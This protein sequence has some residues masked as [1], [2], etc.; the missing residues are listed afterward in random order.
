MDQIPGAL[1][2][3]MVI[4]SIGDQV[5]PN[6][7]TSPLAGTTPLAGLLGTNQIKGN[8]TDAELE[9][10]KYFVRFNDADSSHGS[11]ASPGSDGSESAA[12]TEIMTLTTKLFMGLDPEIT[13]SSVVSVA[14]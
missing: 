2:K 12:F 8:S 10:G 7:A 11:L 4:E 5:V 3:Y 1:A 9:T 6:S 13:N 14:E